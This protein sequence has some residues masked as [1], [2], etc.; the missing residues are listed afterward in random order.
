MISGLSTGSGR[1]PGPAGPA[2]PGARC[3]GPLQQEPVHQLA[4][5]TDPDPAAGHRL[6]RHLLRHEVVEGPVQVGQREVHRHPGDRQ[7]RRVRPGIP[8]PSPGRPAARLTAAWPR[9]CPLTGCPCHGPVLPDTPDGQA[10]GQR[11]RPGATA[12]RPRPQAAAPGTRGDAR[13]W[14]VVISRYGAPG[15]V[16]MVTRGACSHGDLPSGSLATPLS[17]PGWQRPFMR[18]PPGVVGRSSAPLPLLLL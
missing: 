6:A 15:D 17:P 2:S 4:S 16:E 18:T 11:P 3:G 13:D 9:G 1:P 12:P 5:K 14:R 8:P 10:P 7:H